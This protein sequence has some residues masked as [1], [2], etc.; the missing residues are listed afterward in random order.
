MEVPVKTTAAQSQLK[1]CITH[2]HCIKEIWVV[3]DSRKA[4]DE[5]IK[6]IEETPRTTIIEKNNYYLHAEAKTRWM[7][8]IDDLEIMLVDNNIE[9]RSESRVGISD[10]GVNKNRV[11]NIGQKMTLIVDRS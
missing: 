10:N 11:N 7:R 2:S 6:I 9:I 8:Y 4:F 5:A 3:N 1:E